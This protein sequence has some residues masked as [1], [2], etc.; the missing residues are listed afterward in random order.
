M[1][2]IR[3]RGGALDVVGIERPTAFPA[4]S[5]AAPQGTR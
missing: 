4:R 1:V 2:T 5:T 3:N